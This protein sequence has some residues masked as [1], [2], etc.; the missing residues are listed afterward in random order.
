MFLEGE[1]LYAY[2][3]IGTPPSV[4]SRTSLV[5]CLAQLGEFAEGIARS[6]EGVRIAEAVAYPTSFVFAYRGVGLLYLCKGDVQKAIPALEH[7]VALCQDAN[8]RY[9]FLWS[10][11]DLGAAYTLAGRVAE[12]LPLL[13]QAVQQAT[14]I[15]IQSGQ[16]LRVAF[17]SEATLLAG[18]LEEALSLAQQA[19]ELART[20]KERGNEAWILRLL[21]EIAA[22]CD[23]PEV[24]QAETY[25]HEALALATRIRQPPPPPPS[26]PRSAPLFGQGGQPRQP[27]P[28]LPP[29]PALPCAVGAARF[30]APPRRCRAL[31]LP[32]P[33]ALPAGLAFTL[34]TFCFSARLCV[35]APPGPQPCQKGV[36]FSQTLSLFFAFFSLSLGGAF[37]DS[38]VPQGPLYNP[39]E[40][41]TSSCHMRSHLWELL[42]LSRLRRCM[43]ENNGTPCASGSMHALTNGLIPSNSS[44]TSRRQPS[45][46]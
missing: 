14:S 7:S 29:P 38:D 37:G 23:P 43:Q 27:L 42:R 36:G 16:S 26:P 31:Q 20:H 39:Q 12:A 11:S 46:R 8:L 21:G 33:P 40:S 3:G 5:S 4:A 24:E 6:D 17:L 18:R 28:P 2:F 30:P 32:P 44:G 13:E 19:L 34:S 15:G 25:Y 35:S 10:A 1:L 45:W 22:R 9:L 41:I